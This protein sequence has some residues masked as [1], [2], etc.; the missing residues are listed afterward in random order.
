MGP[1]IPL[2]FTFEYTALYR[3][4]YKYSTHNSHIFLDFAPP[5]NFAILY[6]NV[7]KT[8]K[9]TVNNNNK[10]TERRSL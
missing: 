8:E 9:R 5:T 4:G 7:L 2:Y 10:K 1:N 6:P 3:Y